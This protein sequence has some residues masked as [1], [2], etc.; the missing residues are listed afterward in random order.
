MRECPC[1]SGKD[2]EENYD[3]RGIYLCRTCPDCHEE[4][5]GGYRQDVLTDSNYECDEP[6]GE[7]DYY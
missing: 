6:I 1:G 3:A 5:M 7:E 4:K 2:S